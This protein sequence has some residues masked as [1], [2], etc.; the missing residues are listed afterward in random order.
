MGKSKDKQP[1]EAAAHPESGKPA[2]KVSK[3]AFDPTLASLFASSVC[4]LT[5]TGTWA[6]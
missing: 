6:C 4:L 5:K 3:K 1:A 2:L